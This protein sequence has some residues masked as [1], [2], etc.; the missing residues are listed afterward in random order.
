[1][2]VTLSCQKKKREKVGLLVGTLNNFRP[3][4]LSLSA[5]GTPCKT[6]CMYICDGLESLR[7]R[8]TRKCFNRFT[9]KC[10]KAQAC[11]LL[12]SLYRVQPWS[13]CLVMRRSSFDESTIAKSR[14]DHNRFQ[15]KQPLLD[16]SNSCNMVRWMNPRYRGWRFAYIIVRRANPADKQRVIVPGAIAR[17]QMAF[18]SSSSE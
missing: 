4:N 18:S 8:S 1:M 15:R 9:T 16:D 13:Y 3:R 10:S 2:H 12:C 11:R 7:E 14:R 17:T 5:R 6:P